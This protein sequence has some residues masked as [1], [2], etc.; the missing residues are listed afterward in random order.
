MQFLPEKTRLI[1]ILS[2][3]NLWNDNQYELG[4]IRPD[5]IN[6][7]SAFLKAGKILTITGVRR[8]GKSTIMKQYAS[9]LVNEGIPQNN[10]LF[11]NFE[12]AEF[13]N[14]NLILLLKIYEA[15]KEI[16]KPT[17]KP[18]I[19]L[20]EIQNVPR[21][22]KF[23]RSINERKE[24][25]II[26]SGSNAK[27][28]SQEFATILTGRQLVLS[29]FPLSFN[30]FLLFNDI[31]KI[32]DKI[33]A[34]NSEKIRELFRSYINYG[35]FPEVTISNEDDIKIRLL[36]TYLDDIIQ[37]DIVARHK[38]RKIQE[39]HSLVKYYINNFSN[40][41]TYNSIRKF[42]DL[43]I[44]TIKEYSHYFVETN[45]IFFIKRFSYSLKTQEK[46]SRKL[47]LIDTGLSLANK[48]KT[49][50]NVGRIIE[51]LVAI[52]LKFEEF[53]NPGNNTYYWKD[54]YNRKEVDFIVQNGNEICEVIQVCWDISD[55]KTRKRE[56]S[57]MLSA[58]E[59]FQLKEGLI[60]TEDLEYTESINGYIIYYKPIWKWLLSSS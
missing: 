17:D 21:W 45:L 55:E 24:A 10:I 32:D 52:K 11:V 4:V 49:S 31:P 2:K 9:K 6:K 58:M 28:L 39:L 14:P 18:Y 41:I 26:I 48:I 50:K 30:E 59:E 3:W 36:N 54:N 20:D 7:M 43:E 33:I 8:S 56:I 15:Y 19:F 35:G 5:Y 25:H 42:I 53:K 27:M 47:Y 23:V 1:E 60:I 38:I 37:R 44:K 13:D 46:N 16:L 22:E 29:V 34:L 51:N 40:Q 12:E 57:A